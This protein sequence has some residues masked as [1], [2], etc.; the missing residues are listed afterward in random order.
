[1]MKKILLAVTF[2]IGF[3][4]AAFAGLDEG[5]AAFNAGNF[6][7]ALK[8][9]APLA[10]RGNADAQSN[11]GIMYAMGRGVPLDYWQ[12]TEWFRKAAEQGSAT[13]QYNLGFHYAQGQGVPQD[14][15]IAYMLCSLAAAKGN[16]TVAATCNKFA[17][18]LTPEQIQDARNLVTNWKPGSPLPTRSATGSKIEDSA[19][20]VNRNGDGK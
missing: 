8:E 13:A 3:Q 11:L 5:T 10:E 9:W 14:R 6:A 2:A 16:E 1:M 20:S 12:A 17:E 15:V 7:E 18:S 4:T 19:A